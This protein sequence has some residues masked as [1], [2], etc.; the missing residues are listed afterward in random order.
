MEDGWIDGVLSLEHGFGRLLSVLN[1][2]T[3]QIKFENDLILSLTSLLHWLHHEI[4][5]IKTK[6]YQQTHAVLISSLYH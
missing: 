1:L 2:L 3:I 6:G 4:I 5:V